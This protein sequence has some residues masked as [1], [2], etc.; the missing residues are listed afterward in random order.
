MAVA[1]AHLDILGPEGRTRLGRPLYSYC[2]LTEKPNQCLVVRWN[3][4]KQVKSV[5]SFGC[6]QLRINRVR[7]IF[8]TKT[9]WK[10]FTKRQFMPHCP[11]YHST[12]HAQTHTHARPR[13]QGD[14]N[15]HASGMAVDRPSH[16]Q[17]DGVNI[18]IKHL[19]RRFLFTAWLLGSDI[20]W[21]L[22]P[23]SLIPSLSLTVPLSL[24]HTHHSYALSLW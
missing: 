7:L 10:G 12:W 15:S 14:T 5:F 18:I 21:S 9:S 17:M 20:S 2:F 23:S 3:F 16:W 24:S 13:A 4:R 22:P 8:S 19:G 1:G 6:L 11:G